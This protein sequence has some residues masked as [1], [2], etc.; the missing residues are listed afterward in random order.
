MLT[1]AMFLVVALTFA[2]TSLSRATPFTIVY[3]GTV[4]GSYVNPD[5]P[6]G[7]TFVSFGGPA[8]ETYLFDTD[9]LVADATYGMHD[10]YGEGWL[11]I[12]ATSFLFGSNAY[13]NTL[14]MTIT[15][16]IPVINS[17]FFGYR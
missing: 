14:D 5:Y 4:T 7:P 13:G 17:Y 6:N 16:G 1:R 8:T 11:Q 2:S 9:R 10:A 15:G 3:T 12:A